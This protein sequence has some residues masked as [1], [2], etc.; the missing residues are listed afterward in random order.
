MWCRIEE[1][2]RILRRDIMFKILFEHLLLCSQNRSKR[3]KY[4]LCKIDVFKNIAD[5]L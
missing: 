4:K 1:K 3:S 2:K 5:K